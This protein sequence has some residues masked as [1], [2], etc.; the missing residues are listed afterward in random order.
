MKFLLIIVGALL[1][2][3]ALVFYGYVVPLACG[4][5][6]TGCSQSFSFVDKE[7]LV[8]FWPAFLLGVAMMGSGLMWRSRARGA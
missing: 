2:L 4:M 5:N 6:T 1:A 7:S 3:A 8:L